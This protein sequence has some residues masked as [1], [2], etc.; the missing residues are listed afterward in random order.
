MSS[1]NQRSPLKMKKYSLYPLVFL[2]A[3][4]FS[5]CAAF[6]Q[7]PSTATETSA[8]SDENPDKNPIR[9]NSNKRYIKH[10]RANR[11][12]IHRLHRL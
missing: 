2:S 7:E 3:L 8:V 1:F 4:C 9:L 12:I 6:Q 10:R 5:G 11:R